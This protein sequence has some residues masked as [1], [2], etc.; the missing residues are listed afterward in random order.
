MEDWTLKD[1]VELYGLDRWGDGFFG[2]NDRGSV[3]V[4][5][6]RDKGPRVDLMSLVDELKADAIGIQLV[7]TGSQP[8]NL[9]VQA[10]AFGEH[11]FTSVKFIEHDNDALNRNAGAWI[12]DS[13]N[14]VQRQVAADGKHFAVQL[15]PFTSV[16][17]E[18]GMKRFA[19][20]PTYAFPWHGNAVPVE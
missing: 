16:R 13:T 8:R 5:P 4:L 2:V 17:M 10:G 14:P 19:N 6:L 11:A 12:R 18:A 9:I 20:K 7:N 15:P 3:E 1:S